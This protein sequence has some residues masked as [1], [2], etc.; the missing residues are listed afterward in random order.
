MTSA[1]ISA[2]VDRGLALIA[3]S[4]TIQEEFK[5]IITRLEQAAL[6][7]EQ[8]PLTDEQREGMQFL[9]K[10]SS[11]LVPIIITADAV[12]QTFADGSPA[13]GRI[14]EAAQGHLKDFFKRSV[15]WKLMARDGKAF[16]Q[17]AAAILADNA[18]A[19][20][21]ACL[22]RDKNGVPKNLVKIEWD[23]AKPIAA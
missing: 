8:I 21:S 14:E 5:G 4:E 15:T 9:A 3:Q 2:D 11:A 10:G 6:E 17:E 16:R 12:S 23:R 1:Q 7:G 22:S 13:H 19:F 18:P 20:I